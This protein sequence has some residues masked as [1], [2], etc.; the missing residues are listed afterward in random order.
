MSLTVLIGL[1]RPTRLLLSKLIVHRP[2]D[3]GTNRLQF[4]VLVKEF[5]RP[6]GLLRLLCVTNRKAL[7]LLEKHLVWCG[8]PNDS[9]VSVLRT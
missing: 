8:Q 4:T 5:P 6:S 9:A 1:Y 7:S 3:D 2:Q